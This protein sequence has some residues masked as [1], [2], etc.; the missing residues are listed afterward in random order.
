MSMNNINAVHKLREQRIFQE[1][2]LIESTIQKDFFGS[3]V[4]KT[5][6]LKISQMGIDHCMC[7]E[8]ND[9][10][11]ALHKV[12]FTDISKI[13]GMDPEELAAVYGLVPKTARFKR[14]DTNK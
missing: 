1:T 14:K 5:V 4:P 9:A 8:Y 12:K 3:P 2:S 7:E 6:T 10:S 11:G 13:D